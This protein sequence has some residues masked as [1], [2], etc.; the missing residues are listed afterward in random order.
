M[1]LR[2]FD[3]TR[4]PEKNPTSNA[5]HFNSSFHS[6]S[7][8]AYALGFP[9]FSLLPLVCF[10]SGYLHHCRP[11]FFRGEVDQDARCFRFALT[12]LRNILIFAYAKLTG[13]LF[14]G[15]DNGPNTIRVLIA[16]DNHVGYE[17]KNPIRMDDAWKTFDEIMTIAKEQEVSR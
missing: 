6:V 16:T 5:C 14:V 17:E 1:H 4:L 12:L 15:R 10:N 2:T 3:V 11:F 9:S 13:S 8:E 7:S